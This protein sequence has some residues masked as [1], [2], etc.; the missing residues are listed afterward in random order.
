MKKKLFSRDNIILIGIILLVFIAIAIAVPPVFKG[1]AEQQATEVAVRVASSKIQADGTVVSENEAVLHF[2]TGGKLTF[3]PVKAG[4][5][6]YTGETIASLDTYALQQQLTEAL[7]TYRS[8]RDSFDQ[9]QQNAGNNVLQKTQNTALNVAGAGIGTYGDSKSSTDYINDI[10]KRLADQSQAT[11]DNSVINVQLANYAEQLASLTSPINGVL[12]HEDV[13]NAGV[14]VTP[15]T[16]FVVDDPQHLVFRANVLENDID[17]VAVGQHATIN[18]AS[19]KTI[20]GTVDKIYPEKITLPSGDKAYQVDIQSSDLF[21]QAKMSETGTVLIDNVE[22]HDVIQVPSWVVLAG[23]YVWVDV[24][25][26]PKL[27][28][29]TVGDEHGNY[30]EITNGL[31]D[32][33]KVIENPKSIISNKYQIL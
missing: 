29:V 9:T 1:N 11:L 30:T 23:N 27:T 16:T 4:D 6:V 18:M 8:T 17:Y 13:T 25:G 22:G 32:K 21:G 20:S 28:K 12:T 19:G 14:N 15:A 24:N 7:N 31:S 5:K 26:I 10:V 3:L 2:Q 33:D